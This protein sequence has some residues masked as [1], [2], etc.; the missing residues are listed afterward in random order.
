MVVDDDRVLVQQMCTALETGGVEV[1][2]C[3]TVSEAVTTLAAW[4]PDLVV[5]DLAL[6]D[7]DAFDVLEM[8]RDRAPAPLVVVISG[9]AS[10]R[11][12]F[13]LAELG[14][15]SYLS[16]PFDDHELAAAIQHAVDE[17]PNIKPQLRQLVG[18]R[19]IHEV[20]E[21]V[22]AAMLDEAIA[23]SGGSRRGAAR[24]LQVSR[25]LVQRMLRIRE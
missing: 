4:L 14:V 3:T 16:K 11:Q 24:L 7:G 10:A 12:S 22:R 19:S 17:A 5:L 8:L 15:R 6:P 18:Q 1:R 2:A 21:E 20:E 25:Q 23:R 13:R 9:T